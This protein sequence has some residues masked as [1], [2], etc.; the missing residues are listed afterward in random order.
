MRFTSD[1]LTSK[2]GEMEGK[3]KN[4]DSLNRVDSAHEASAEVEIECAFSFIS[5]TSTQAGAGA[6]VRVVHF[7]ACPAP[8]LA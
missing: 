3:R 7:L 2:Y 1:S 8:F 5:L 6:G 4:A